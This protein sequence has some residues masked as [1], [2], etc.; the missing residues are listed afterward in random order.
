MDRLG[1][2]H[3]LRPDCGGPRG[4]GWCVQKVVI[5]GTQQLQTMAADRR[6]RPRC[7]NYGV[8]QD[9]ADWAT[10][11][12]MPRGSH[13]GMVDSNSAVMRLAWKCSGSSLALQPRGDGQLVWKWV[14]AAML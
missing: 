2:T 5:D 7:Q 11:Q 14:C 1:E 8:K 10:Q 12:R 13:H 3:G 9:C 4:I 6:M